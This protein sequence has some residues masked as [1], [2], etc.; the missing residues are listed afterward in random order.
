MRT[1]EATDNAVTD[2]TGTLA[3]AWQLIPFVPFF[4]LPPRE[5][6]IYVL[7]LFHIPVLGL[8]GF[9]LL[10]ACI[11]ATSTT[12]KPQFEK[13]DEKEWDEKNKC[14]PPQKGGTLHST[15][16][17]TAVLLRQEQNRGICTDQRS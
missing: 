14:S 15:C 6:L 8:K 10:I 4:L 17:L 5:L 7:Q 12:P 16:L 1:S 13:S 2:D 11:W 9:Y 3:W